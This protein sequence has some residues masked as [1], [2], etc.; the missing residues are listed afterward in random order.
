MQ[1][2]PVGIIF[3]LFKIKIRIKLNN[4]IDKEKKGL[5]QYFKVFVIGLLFVIGGGGGGGEGGASEAGGGIIDSFRLAKGL[6]GNDDEDD[7]IAK[8]LLF[9]KGF[10]WFI[11]C[12]SS[13]SSDL[14]SS[15]V[16]MVSSKFPCLEEN[17][18]QGPDLRCL[19]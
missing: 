3:A 5:S 13:E 15:F 1:K 10:C 9:A 19:T 17:A 2:M 14:S 8:A 12:S 4:F 18:M 7:G 11:I 16:H 6:G